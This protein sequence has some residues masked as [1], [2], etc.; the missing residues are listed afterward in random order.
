ME[1]TTNLLP[2][3]NYCTLMD[4][5]G[6]KGIYYSQTN[7][8]DLGLLERISQIHNYFAHVSDN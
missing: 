3:E 7:R 6:P 8:I 5:K 4:L 2:D 1:G